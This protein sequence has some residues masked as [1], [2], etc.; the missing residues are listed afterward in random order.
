MFRLGKKIFVNRP[1]PSPVKGKI[2]GTRFGLIHVQT[3]KKILSRDPPPPWNSKKL[4]WLRDG[5]LASCVHAAGLSCSNLMN[6]LVCITRFWLCNN[7]VF[8]KLY[9]VILASKAAVVGSNPTGSNYFSAAKFSSSSRK[10][11]GVNKTVLLRETCPWVPPT[12][13]WGNPLPGTGYPRLGWGYPLPH[14]GLGYLPN[15]QS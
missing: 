9:E 10:I 13:D 5:R 3:G 15:P 14:L 12:W 11:I 4:L 8:L 7:R 1:P 6:A 2:V